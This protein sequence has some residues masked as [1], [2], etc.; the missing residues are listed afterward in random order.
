MSLS[1]AKF[2]LFR[3]LNRFFK[4]IQLQDEQVAPDGTI[5][6]LLYEY[7]KQRVFINWVCSYTTREES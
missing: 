4:R 6:E 3:G 7:S 5:C 2:F 1:H